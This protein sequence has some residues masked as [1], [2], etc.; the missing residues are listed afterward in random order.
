MAQVS[1]TYELRVS[2]KEAQANVDELNKSFQAQE[3]LVADLE[4]ELLRYNKSLK[5]TEGFSGM[6]MAKRSH[7]NKK[8]AETKQ[9]LAEEKQGLKDVTRDRKRANEELKNAQKDAADYNG[10]LGLLDKQTGGLISTTKN[11]TGSIGS[12]TK[13]SKLLSIAM[14]GIPLIAIATAIIG[15][16]KAFTSSEEGQ[17]KFRKFFTQIKV[18]IGNVSD[19]LSDFGNAVISLFTGDFKAAGEALDQVR[20]GIAN[21]GEETKK[22]IKLA[23]ELSDKRAEADKL[24]RDLLVER[25]EATRKFNELRERAADKENVSVEDR[26]ALLKEAGRI[27]EEITLKEIDAAKK[28]L[29]AKQLENSLSKSTKEDLDEEAKLKA[30]LIELESKRLKKQK[31]LTTEITRNLREQKAEEKR[32]E[33]EAARDKEEADKKAIQDAKDLADLKKQIRDATAT[34]EAELRELELIKIDEHFER[35]KLQ[36]E[37]QGLE[38][39]ELENARLEQRAAKTKEF[40][41]QDIANAK[42]A[43]D[44]KKAVALAEFVAEKQIQGQ[45]FALL[46]QFGGF[47]SSIAGENKKLAIAG[48]IAQQAGAIGQIVSATGIANA[49]AVAATPLT[50]G[51]P[52]VTLNTISAALSV[53]SAVAQAAKSI[54]QIKSSGQS[55]NAMA[56]PSLPTSGGG[57]SAPVVA[58]LPPDVTGVGGSGVNQ[59]ATAIGEQQQQPVQAF[60]VSN[61]VT[62]AQ[63]L[64][65]NIIDGASL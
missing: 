17:N 12:A 65:R 26:I 38:T 32:I 4:K 63:G 14:K 58:P 3:D 48:V 23:G 28:R 52:F 45:K 49:K 24:E 20:E 44:E 2:T 30:K 50:F 55:A 25:A 29:E 31:T 60:V 8:I 41:D 46:S 21:F 36:A 59:L 27:E 13:G 15:V 22:E 64:E 33:D 1:K 18:V 47:L 40:R 9:R 39:T 35:L 16:A 62:T 56:A 6:A 19:I 51:Q 34:S 57:A 5:E 11:F 61:D 54:Q 37:E 43:A 7:L 42:K 53:A 10:V